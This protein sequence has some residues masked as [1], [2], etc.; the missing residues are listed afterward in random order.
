MHAGLLHRTAEV[1]ANR[2]SVVKRQ[3]RTKSVLKILT[4]IAN[5]SE[6]R[7]H[8]QAQN[9]SMR[10]VTGVLTNEPADVAIV[11][12]EIRVPILKRSVLSS[13]SKGRH[14]ALPQHGT[15][16]D[17]PQLLQRD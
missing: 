16:G 1:E 11:R 17:A 14:F 8:R 3:L 15:H 2:A 5:D 6:P 9:W 13:E 12:P 4:D 10:F 7:R